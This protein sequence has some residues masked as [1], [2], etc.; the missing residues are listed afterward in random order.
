[1]IAK[2]TNGNRIE[3]VNRMRFDFI[4]GTNY[5]KGKLRP[6]GKRMMKHTA[7]LLTFVMV[8]LLFSVNVSAAGDI[9]VDNRLSVH[10]GSLLFEYPLVKNGF[11]TS[12]HKVTDDLWFVDGADLVIVIPNEV[13]ND[14]KLKLTL[15]NAEW[16]FEN[17]YAQLPDGKTIYGKD[18]LSTFD[19]AKGTYDDVDDTYTRTSDGGLKTTIGGKPY[20]EVL[21]RLEITPSKP[22]IATLT[23][24]NGYEPLSGSGVYYGYSSGDYLLR[25]PL[26]TFIEDEGVEATVTVEAGSGFHAIPKT[27]IIFASTKTDDIIVTPTPTLTPAPY[28]YYGGN[29]YGT[30]PAAPPSN[31]QTKPGTPGGPA[32][33]PALLNPIHPAGASVKAAPS[34]NTLVLNGKETKFP[35]F[36][37]SDYNFLKLR[38][39]AA[40]LNGTEKQFS[41]GWDPHTNTVTIET[42]KGYTSVGDELKD[43]VNGNIKAVATPQKIIVDGKPISIAAYNINGYN[44]FR[45]RDIA[46]L[47]NF[48]V[49]WEGTGGVIT[50]DLKRGYSGE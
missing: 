24:I 25:I 46:I 21:Y 18:M 34:T 41:I 26:V 8:S 4:K 5:K 20:S 1:M 40:L 23:V 42:G 17:D 9:Y 33:P 27:P 49:D 6:N 38:D 16:K 19:E 50:L 31:E 14:A 28:P 48:A 3:G 47:L 10:M 39:I 15:G 32:G 2:I 13:G 22:N 44:Y 29:T 45:L 43:L 36:V 12:M 11:G 30:S 37:I 7:F 35:A